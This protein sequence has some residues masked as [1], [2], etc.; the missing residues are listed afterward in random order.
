[1]SSIQRWSLVSI[2]VSFFV[3]KYCVKSKIAC[4]ILRTCAT[5]C[6]SLRS[7]VYSHEIGRL[8]INLT[9]NLHVLPHW[10]EMAT[11]ARAYVHWHGIGTTTMVT[12]SN[13]CIAIEYHVQAILR[14]WIE[15]WLSRCVSAAAVVIPATLVTY[16]QSRHVTNRVYM[17][18]TDLPS[19][20]PSAPLNYPH[21]YLRLLTY[22]RPHFPPGLVH[23]L[24]QGVET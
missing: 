21:F 2:I 22:L 8:T 4:S 15:V 3:C 1:M 16:R 12:T 13:P 23:R 19:V 5:Y 18:P 7:S 20:H 24:C 11:L 10:H 6:L 9:K 14:K 17:R